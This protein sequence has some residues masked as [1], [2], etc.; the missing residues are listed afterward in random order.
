MRAV[1]RVRPD[2]RLVQTEDLGKTYGTPALRYQVDFENE[3]RWLS[4]DLLSGRVDRAHPMWSYLRW[5]EVPEGEVGWFLDNP[6]PPDLF[7]INHYVTSER[8]LDTR[9]GR[10][11]PHTHGGNGRHDY[12]D[13]EAVRVGSVEGPG[14]VLR[15]AWRRYGRP[16]AVTEAHLACTREEQMRW[17]LEVWRAAGAVRAEGADIRAVTVWSLLGAYD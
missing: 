7:G 15:E 2:A 9:L 8:F 3:R 4:F 13:V 5:A 10:Y 12:A 1:R 14:G 17:L 11:P 6:C 16:L